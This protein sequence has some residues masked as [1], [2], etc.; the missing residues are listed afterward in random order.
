MI[1]NNPLLRLALP[2]IIGIIIGWNF[3][4]PPGYALFMA[5]LSLLAM[6]LGLMGSSPRALL[7]V[8][9]LSF[10]LS[11]GIYVEEKAEAA[12]AQ[13]WSDS[14]CV[15][16]ATLLEEPDVRQSTV[17]VLAD[18]SYTGEA[19]HDSVRSSGRAYLYFPRCTE[20][21]ALQIGSNVEF[22]GVISPFRN[23]GNPAEFDTERYY[24]IKDISG[25]AFVDSAEWVD[26]GCDGLSLRMQAL[27][28]RSSVI[29]MYGRLQFESRELA[30]LSALTVG[31]KDDFPKELREEYSAAGASHILALSGL[32]LGIFYALLVTLLPLWGRN[33]VMVVVRELFIVILIWA[34]A[35]MAGLS[36]S[37][38]RAA[39]LF[40]LM[41]A[42]QCMRRDA[43]LLSSLSFAA[44][45]ML[46]VSPHLLFDMSFQLSFAAVLSILLFAPPL[47]RLIKVDERGRFWR[48][49][50]N[51]MIVSL[52]AQ[53]GTLPLVWYYFGMFPIYFLLTNIVIVPLAFLL[54]LLAVVLCIFSFF[55]MLQL[56]LARVV[57]F[58]AALMN[59]CVAAVAG[60]PG[61]SLAMP[62]LG[63]V[64]ACL[65]AAM[66]FAFVYS[67]T[68]RKWWL[69]ALS[70]GA[71]L[72]LPFFASGPQTDPA[73]GNGIIVY[74]NRKN[75]L[76]HVVTADGGNWLVSTVPQADAEYE[77]SSAP[78]VKREGLPQPGW[79]CDGHSDGGL[80]FDMGL[81]QFDGLK[82]RLIDNGLWRD[83]LYVEPTDVVVLCRGFKGSVKE[84]IEVYEPGC[85]M[86]DASLYRK[87]RE[88]LLH[89]CAAAEVEPVDISE[90]GA[91]KIVATQEGFRVVPMRGR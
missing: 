75:P 70:V 4:V 53:L 52:A 88:R 90:Q 76:L 74:N 16:S 85:I 68:V 49:V 57:E 38:V 29:D 67:L 18:V 3:C 5:L 11:A 78:Y 8:G 55:P 84:L 9:A 65:V 27:K 71:M 36:P 73:D 69:T 28:L 15:Y 62:P 59:D 44:I 19:L 54:V 24:Y 21:E 1:K 7:G 2:L 58:V 30:L 80:S 33:R 12:K 63:V 22:A 72:L 42:G 82:V 14:K 66:I 45:A 13:Q 40:T 35:F 23:A 34:F 64:E 6:L 20:A 48:F 47:Q 91:M 10:M 60:M 26:K 89:E 46:L 41:A 43:S 81:L 17:R 37:V 50:L 51:L 25:T 86:L 56:P 83:N 31:E 87:S 79:A 39:I 61:A 32:H 77:Y